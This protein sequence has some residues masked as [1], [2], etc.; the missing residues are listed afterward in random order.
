MKAGPFQWL[1]RL[2]EDMHQLTSE[3]ARLHWPGLDGS[4]EPYFNYRYEHICQVEREALRLL[5]AEGGD[6]EILLAAVWIHDRCQPQYAGPPDHA[7][8]AAHWARDNL[9]AFGFPAAKVP[10]VCFAVAN[11]SNSP[12][13]LAGQAQEARMLWDAD[14]LTKIGAFPVIVYLCGFPAFPDKVMTLQ[15]IVDHGFWH[16]QRVTQLVENFYFEKSRQ[17]ARLKLA[18]E[19]AYYAALAEEAGSEL[20]DKI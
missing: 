10:E 16:L 4:A 11:H 7:A 6:A 5:D 9:A 18:A 17:R 12:G 14:K 3:A 15:S 2:R 8:Q 1:V 20:N 19:R 13:S